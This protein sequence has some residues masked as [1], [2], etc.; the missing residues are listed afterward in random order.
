[1]PRYDPKRIKDLGNQLSES[2]G[3]VAAALLVAG[4]VALVASGIVRLIASQL[5]ASYL[6][7]LAIGLL[8]VLGAAASGYDTIRSN[9]MTRKGFYGFNT[10]VMVLLFLAL[11][12][13]IIF[14]GANNNARFDT[15]SAREFSL[16]KQTNEILSGLRNDVEAVAFFESTDINQ[17]QIRVPA[18]DLLE[19]YAQTTR[20]FGYRIV[21][22]DIEPEEARRYGIN[23]DTEPG[24]IVFASGGNLQPVE[25]LAFNQAAGSFIPNINL[26]RDFSQAIL[27]VTRTQQKRVYFTVRH[28]ERDSREPSEGNGYGLA[29]LGLEGDNYEVLTLDVAARANVPEDAAVLII[30]GPQN[31]LLDNEIEPI[32][33]FLKGGGKALF[34]F[35][36]DT[37]SRFQELVEE[38]GVSLGEGMV[39]DLGSSVSG[40]PR[41]PLITKDRF[42][43]LGGALTNPI[44]QPITDSTFF[45]RAAALI[46]LENQGQFEEPP[47]PNIYYSS[48]TILVTPLLT[49]TTFLSW[50]ETDPEEIRPSGDEVSGPLALGVSIDAS[51][52]FGEEAPAGD[53]RVRTQ[54]VVI[55]DSDFASNRFVTSFANQDLL[56]NSVN[57]LAGDVELISVRA[58]LRQ[59]RLLIVTQGTFNFIRWSSLLILPVVVASAGVYTWW[60][61]R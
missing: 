14:I 31:D 27:A 44:T 35:D 1:M 59:P 20:R 56:L 6:T 11:A 50:L 41:A 17:V 36:P 48:E 30:A 37:P 19:E 25:T 5:T 47:L 3:N 13:L 28:G 55:G 39:V 18:E 9:L 24:T 60:R 52:P 34:L 16:A 40:N 58:K 7:L 8:L 43:P 61:R 51:A 42:K 10:T 22:P 15:T 21:D 32:R 45:D 26:E 4:V 54:I 33:E 23:P 38:W 46:P 12:S 2:L 29:R 53:E 57:W 49:S